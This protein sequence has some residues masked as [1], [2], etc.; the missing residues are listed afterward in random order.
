MQQLTNNEINNIAKEERKVLNEL[1]QVFNF[2]HGAGTTPDLSQNAITNTAVKVIVSASRFNDNNTSS[3]QDNKFE[4]VEDIIDLLS[5]VTDTELENLIVQDG[6]YVK[7]ITNNV[8]P[9][10]KNG[11]EARSDVDIELTRDTFN[12]QTYCREYGLQLGQGILD[13]Y[14]KLDNVNGRYPWEMTSKEV[15]QIIKDNTENFVETEFSRAWSGRTAWD[16]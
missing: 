7:H 4:K 2:L 10:T 5:K 12:L 15:H 14:E 9:Y 6:Y 11:V 16:K 13:I 1:S 8:L 3:K